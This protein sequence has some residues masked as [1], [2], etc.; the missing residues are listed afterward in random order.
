MQFFIIIN[1]AVGGSFFSD[2]LKNEPH[3][4]PYN[5]SSGR[6]MR[7][8]WEKKDWWKDSWQGERAALQV[9]YVRVYQ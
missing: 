1:L 4:R 6:A 2:D 7:Q 9:D 8:F 5:L 3:P